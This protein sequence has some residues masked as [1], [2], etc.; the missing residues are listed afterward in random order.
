MGFEFFEAKRATD[1]IGY[2]NGT[3]VAT[4]LPA[5]KRNPTNDEE[6]VRLLHAYRA[7]GLLAQVR[8]KT[9]TDT[10][11]DYHIFSEE[12]VECLSDSKEF[13]EAHGYTDEIAG[14]TDTNGN[15]V[16]VAIV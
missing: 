13:K 16:E 7:Q 15:P 2:V 12:A 14:A 10:Y 1:N 6:T 4:A 3:H 8:C 5:L 9:G 11:K